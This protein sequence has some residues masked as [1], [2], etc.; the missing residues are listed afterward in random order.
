MPSPPCPSAKNA[1]AA[2]PI[3]FGR[4]TAS[5]SACASS[6]VGLTPCIPTAAARRGRPRASWTSVEADTDCEMLFART[7][8]ATGGREEDAEEGADEDEGG[9]CA[10]VA[11][12]RR[13]G[14]SG[15]CACDEVLLVLV[16]VVATEE[17]EEEESAAVSRAWWARMC[18]RWE[19]LRSEQ[20]TYLVTTGPP[21]VCCAFPIAGA[22]TG[23]VRNG[24]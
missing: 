24:K 18:R 15:G 13:G 9:M 11:L 6:I 22:E 19:D 5:W 4:F 3:P 7:R 20:S 10:D 16:V 1:H 21:A 14:T 23:G 8:V 12:P 2:C 17:E